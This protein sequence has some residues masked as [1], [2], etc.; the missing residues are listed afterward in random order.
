LP[1]FSMGTTMACFREHGTRPVR[2]MALNNRSTT[3]LPVAGN[4]CRNSYVTRSSPGDDF[5]LTSPRATVSSWR[6]KSALRC[7]DIS[8]SG[9]VVCKQV[10]VVR[11]HIILMSSKCGTVVRRTTDF[12]EF[13]SQ[14][15][16][17]VAVSLDQL[18]AVRQRRAG[19]AAP[20]DAYP[21]RHAPDSRQAGL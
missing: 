15:F 19:G 21:P 20:S 3:C 7:R 8:V 6:Q 14:K 16:G 17:L 9:S 5:R 11:L 18:I 4:L 1:T 13:L 10:G 2:H 12:G